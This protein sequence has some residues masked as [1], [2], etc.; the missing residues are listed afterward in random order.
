VY[1]SGDNQQYIESKLIKNWVPSGLA[2]RGSVP[3]QEQKH[4]KEQII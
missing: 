3:H 1:K 4:K 2:T